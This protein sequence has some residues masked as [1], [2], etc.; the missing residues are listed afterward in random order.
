MDI[1]PAMKSKV[2]IVMPAYNAASTLEK[3]IKDIPQG[4]ADEI[5]LVDDSSQDDTVRIARSLGLTVMVHK[6]NMGY[7][8]NQKTCY[9]EAL[10]RNPDIVIMIHPDYQYEP[11]RNWHK[12]LHKHHLHIATQTSCRFSPSFLSSLFLTFNLMLRG[13]YLPFNT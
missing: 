13:S 2:I 10:K 3:T 12:H 7:G 6:G 4:F 11:I 1:P 5:V 9:D 8:A